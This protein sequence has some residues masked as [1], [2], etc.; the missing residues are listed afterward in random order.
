[1]KRKELKNLAEKIAKKCQSWFHFENYIETGFDFTTWDGFGYEI[2]K[3]LHNFD[4]SE[5]H[6]LIDLVVNCRNSLWV[7]PYEKKELDLSGKVFV[8]TGKLSTFKNR[9]EAKTAIENK[10][11]KVTNSVTGNTNYLVNNDINSMSSKNVK[12]KQL[13]IPIIN[14]EQLIAML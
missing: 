2:N 8:I 11:G 13:G 5:A 10:G 9:D 4:Y 3:S 12:A 6:I 14:E 7:N 1:M